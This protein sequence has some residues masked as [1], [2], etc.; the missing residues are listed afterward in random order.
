MAIPTEDFSETVGLPGLIFPFVPHS[1]ETGLLQDDKEA[2]GGFPLFAKKGVEDKVWAEKPTVADESEG[3]E[4]G[5]TVAD[6]EAYFVGIAVRTHMDCHDDGYS[7]GD[8]INV[9]KKGRLWVRVLGEVLAG[10]PAYVNDTNYAITATSEGG[11]A[12]PGGVF[13]TNAADGKLAQLEIA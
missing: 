3:A 9:L 6:P 5:A 7:K 11:T 4:E 8:H 1:I 12:I 10:Q 13:K 2:G